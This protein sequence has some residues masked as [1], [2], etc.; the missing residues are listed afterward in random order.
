MIERAVSM[1]AR[2]AAGSR[3]D[4]RPSAVPRTSARVRRPMRLSTWAA[5]ITASRGPRLVITGRTKPAPGS[6]AARS[7]SPTS[8]PRP[9][10]E[11]SP[12][13]STRSGNW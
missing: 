10:L 12:S 1:N 6:V 2:R 3:S 8:L 7:T 9:P 5:P 4:A 11:T 13:R